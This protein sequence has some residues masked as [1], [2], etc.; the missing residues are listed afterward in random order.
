MYYKCNNKTIISNNARVTTMTPMAPMSTYMNL[1]AC[2]SGGVNVG[3]HATS[4]VQRYC[5]LR[6]ASFSDCRLSSQ[7]EIR[8]FRSKRSLANDGQAKFLSILRPKNSLFDDVL[9][10]KLLL[11]NHFRECRVNLEVDGGC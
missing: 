8:P 2:V 4:I 11:S 6:I 5:F 7:N 10:D 3:G 9:N 1:N